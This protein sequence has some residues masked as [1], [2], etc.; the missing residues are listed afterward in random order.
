MKEISEV[1][2]TFSKTQCTHTSLATTCKFLFK[3]VRKVKTQFE[4]EIYDHMY[5][6]YTYIPR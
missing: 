4:Q 5:K 1:D 3:V 6:I 2:F